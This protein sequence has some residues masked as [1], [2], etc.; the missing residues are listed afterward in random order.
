MPGREFFSG[1]FFVGRIRMGQGGTACPRRA[2]R[3]T[4][5]KPVSCMPARCARSSARRRRRCFSPRATSTRA[6]RSARLRFS[7]KIAGLRLFALFQP[8]HGHVRAAHGR[9]RRRRGR[10]L[11]RD[12]H[13]GGHHRADGPG[14]R[15]RSRGRRQG[16]VR[17]LPLGDR[18]VAAALRRRLDAGRRQGPR[19]LEEGGA[20][21]HQGVLHGDADQSDAGGVST[22]PRSPTS[23]TR[24]APNSWSTTCSPRRS[25]RAR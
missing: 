20:Q 14:A 7:G 15:R 4:A 6:P 19:R 11:D 22:S 16:A 3:P 18:G 9:A 8:D 1:R 5:P 25:T 10:A 24:P 13:G 2:K 23:R 21:E 17:L 12:R